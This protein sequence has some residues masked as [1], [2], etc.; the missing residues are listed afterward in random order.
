MDKD[1]D[2]FESNFEII[3]K[4]GTRIFPLLLKT[5]KNY[6]NFTMPKCFI[7]III[8]NQGKK[9]VFAICFLTRLFETLIAAAVT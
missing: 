6:E 4:E 5:E 2:E 3:S 9:T 7:I 8:T 1:S